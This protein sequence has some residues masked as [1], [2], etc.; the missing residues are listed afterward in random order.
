[1]YT[2]VKL[3]EDDKKKLEK[4]RALATL[5]TAKKITQEDLLSKLI[6]GALAEGDKFVDR[7]FED[8]VPIPDEKF[9]KISA[10]SK[11][12]NVKTSWEEIDEAVYGSFRAKKGRSTN[13]D[14]KRRRK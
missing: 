1:V 14:A 4:L 3:R 13:S 9:K 10:L 5:K 7:V 8:T 12:W 6:T 2:S 11:D